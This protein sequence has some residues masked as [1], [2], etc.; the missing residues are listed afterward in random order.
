[1]KILPIQFEKVE[2]E[3]GTNRLKDIWTV[4]QEP[5][6]FINLTDESFPEEKI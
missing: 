3:P 6:E 5:M 1:M 4:E 2:T